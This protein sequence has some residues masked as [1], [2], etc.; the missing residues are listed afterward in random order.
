[1]RLSEFRAYEK[2]AVQS[3]FQIMADSLQMKWSTRRHTTITES[4]TGRLWTVTAPPLILAQLLGDTPLR[5][6]HMHSRPVQITSTQDRRWTCG[7]SSAMIGAC[8]SAFGC[9]EAHAWGS[10]LRV[11]S[12]CLFANFSDLARHRKKRSPDVQDRLSPC[13]ISLI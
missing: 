4:Q 8:A 10:G 5:H 6:S 13:R 2:L 3:L 1:M 12:T 7:G 9:R 11:R